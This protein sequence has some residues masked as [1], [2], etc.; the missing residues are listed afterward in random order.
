MKLSQSL[1]VIPGR[2]LDLLIK[3]CEVSG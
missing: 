2:D 1:N 3:K